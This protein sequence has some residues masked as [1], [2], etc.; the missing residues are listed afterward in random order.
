[1]KSW[2]KGKLTQTEKKRY[3]YSAEYFSRGAASELK[4]NFNKPIIKGVEKVI[5]NFNK[6]EDDSQN[7]DKNKSKI[8]QRGLLLAAAL[9]SVVILFN[10]LNKIKVNQSLKKGDVT[11]E[12]YKLNDDKI[13]K[14]VTGDNGILSKL[15]RYIKTDFCDVLINGTK[16]ITTMKPKEMPYEWNKFL[17]AGQLKYGVFGDVFRNVALAAIWHVFEMRGYGIVLKIFNLPKPDQEV[18]NVGMWKTYNDDARQYGHVGRSLINSGVRSAEIISNTE[19]KIKTSITKMKYLANKIN[20]FWK[21]ALGESYSNF[22]PRTGEENN[23]QEIINSLSL[24][25][26]D[27]FK[28]ITEKGTFRKREL[29]KTKITVDATQTVVVPDPNYSYTRQQEVVLNQENVELNFD[30]KDTKKANYKNFAFIESIP[31]K[32]DYGFLKEYMDYIDGFA[33]NQD[34]RVVEMLKELK[35]VLQPQSNKKFK[36]KLV[37]LMYVIQAMTAFGEYELYQA[38]KSTNTQRALY[39]D[40]FGRQMVD[41]Y[42]SSV[43]DIE[44]SYRE[45]SEQ[46]AIDYANGKIELDEYIKEMK[47]S[48]SD[49]IKNPLKNLNMDVKL[50]RNVYQKGI[51]YGELKHFLNDIRKS[52]RKM[53]I[54]GVSDENSLIIN[55]DSF[56]D[57]FDLKRRENVDTNI[58][59]SGQQFGHEYKNRK[60]YNEKNLPNDFINQLNKNQIPIDSVI[61]SVVYTFDKKNQHENGP[62]VIHGSLKTRLQKYRQDADNSSYS[63]SK[64]WHPRRDNGEKYFTKYGEFSSIDKVQF[65]S[66]NGVGWYHVYEKAPNALIYG[67]TFVYE[68]IDL[69]KN[70]EKRFY[71]DNVIDYYVYDVNTKKWKFMFNVLTGRKESLKSQAAIFKQEYDEEK[72]K[73]LY[74]TPIEVLLANLNDSIDYVEEKLLEE[75]NIRLNLLNEL[76]PN[77]EDKEFI[78]LIFS[79]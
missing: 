25:G 63:E 1:M 65:A 38:L 47:K 53:N 50:H 3:Q 12:D 10:K 61:Y 75:Y 18:F 70:N 32:G 36:W 48:L 33:I 58:G 56:R 52:I 35:N 27:N 73:E 51:P 15:K 55:N 21:I 39:Q 76:L 4:N 30:S 22:R 67:N 59:I 66:G 26:N 20:V 77:Q 43:A 7:N 9:G 29:I 42:V 72:I 68:T 79:L 40:F 28:K 24:E 45:T 34:S 14:Q 6:T 57:N 13:L 69:D 44:K 17:S 16:L 60:I 8:L 49:I 11:D 31:F 46:F 2:N 19:E 23:L 71:L 41:D 74:N 64:F 78:D 62:E 54:K 37:D 5:D